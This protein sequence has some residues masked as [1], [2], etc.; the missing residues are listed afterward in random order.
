MANKDSGKQ[1]QLIALMGEHPKTQLWIKEDF[2]DHFGWGDIPAA[3]AV[4]NAFRSGKI[5]KH[6]E[7]D[8]EGNQRYA[9]SIKEENRQI[10]KQSK[11][12][13][14]PKPG[15]P[16]KKKGGLPTSKEIRR[17]FADHM[18]STAQLEDIVLGLA[19]RLEILEK[20]H[21]KIKQLI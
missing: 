11:T 10:Y 20:N 3:N 4:Y 13:S 12:G 17:M 14:G 2:M 18:N 9:L 15:G 7:K 19:D 21:E 5:H 8:K 16:R 1:Q 6:K